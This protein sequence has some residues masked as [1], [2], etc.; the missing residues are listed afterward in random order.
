M[1]V[2]WLVTVGVGIAALAAGVLI[3]RVQA[4][5]AFERA[6]HAQREASG[7]AAQSLREEA[8]QHRAEVERLALALDGERRAL[9]DVT[10]RAEMERGAGVEARAAMD[11]LTAERDK[12]RAEAAKLRLAAA[13]RPV[14]LREVTVAGDALDDL[15]ARIALHQG[16][17][18]AVVT[19]ELGL[20]VATAG[21]DLGEPLAA[22]GRH[23]SEETRR[24]REL[25]P[26]RDITQITV[27]DGEGAVLIVRPLPVPG[28]RLALVTIAAGNGAEGAAREVE[29]WATA[30]AVMS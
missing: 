27:H 6:L 13:V 30:R 19:D 18:G 17:R 12:L 21:G 16:V 23:I 29:A 14:R 20:V 26:L 2:L 10:Q 24:M 4:R 9:A 22:F 25:L 1:T 7:R 5:A 11:K 15:L 8:A 28:H 3:G